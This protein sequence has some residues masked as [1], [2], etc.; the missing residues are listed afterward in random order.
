MSRASSDVDSQDRALLAL[1]ARRHITSTARDDIVDRAGRASDWPRLLVLAEQQGLGPLLYHHLKPAL[2][3][4]PPPVAR[5]LQSIYIR[6]KRAN[7][8]R[9]RVLRQVLD[10]FEDAGILSVVLKGP[11]LI[12]R[13]YGDPGLRPMSDLDLLVPRE[14]A[15]GAQRLL[16]DL[17]FVVRMSPAVH[18][19]NNHHH[20]SPAMRHVNGVAVMV[21]VH[22]D[23]F[24]ATVPESL[25]IHTRPRNGVAFDVCGRRAYSLSPE[26][27][28]WHLCRHSVDFYTPFRMIWG[29]DVVGFAEAFLSTI[30]WERIERCYPFVLSTLSLLHCLA[31]V[32]E[33]VL[34]RSHLTAMETHRV[35][36]DYDGWPRVPAGQWDSIGACLQFLSDTFN[37]SAWWLR[38]NYGTGGSRTGMWRA[39]VRHGAALVRHR[40]SIT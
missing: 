2:A 4:L 13:V 39:R 5:Q 31:P 28:L 10:A 20:L 26:E 29:A 25:E 23:A 9:L 17:G 19:P 22:Q 21:E 32:P 37:P 1:C 38:L 16:A 18:S 30:D 8:I 36:E 15:I 35:G 24:H 7:E 40:M 34:L 33:P 3:G 27:L 14:Q 11:L 12:D 6:H